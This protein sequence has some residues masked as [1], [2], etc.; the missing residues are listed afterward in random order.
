MVH[1]IG[2]YSHS[3]AQAIRLM[4]EQLKQTAQFR[5][6]HVPPS[7][8][9]RFSREENVGC[10]VRKYTMSL[11]RL[12]RIG[13]MG[14]AQWRKYFVQVLNGVMRSSI[15]TVRTATYLV[16]MPLSEAVGL[17]P[18]SKNF[19]VATAFMRNEQAITY[20]WVLQ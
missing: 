18:T 16:Q 10:A 19:T 5:K 11:P 3:R 8:I 17:T 1:K 2:V 4:E 9:L 14:E 13:C 20:R 6:S 7:N 15:E 12:R